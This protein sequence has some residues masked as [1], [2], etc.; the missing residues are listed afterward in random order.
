MNVS[1]NYNLIPY[2]DHNYQ[3]KP[4]GQTNA[5]QN[6]DHGQAPITSG[7]LFRRTH[8]A[9]HAVLLEGRCNAYDVRK[10]LAYPQAHQVGLLIDLYA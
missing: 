3:I 4:Y 2:P 8:S 9:V 5:V 6:Q 7:N 1:S 10:C